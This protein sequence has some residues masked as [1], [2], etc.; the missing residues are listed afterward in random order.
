MNHYATTI[1]SVGVAAAVALSALP[2]R[3]EERPTDKAITHWVSEALQDDP[4]IVASGVAV[5]TNDGIVELSG[6]CRSLTG[7]KFAD[8]EAKKIKGVLGVIDKLKVEP[9]FR[10]DWDIAQDIRHRLL[11]SAFIRSHAL[12]VTVKDGYATLTGEVD[13]W[14]QKQWA[15]LLAGEVRG[16]KDIK[17][18]LKVDYS[19]E[20]PDKE[21]AQDVV[22]SIARDAYLTDLPITATVKDGTVTLTGSVGNWFQKDRAADQA[23]YVNGMRHVR[24]IWRSNGGKN[25]ACDITCPPTQTVKSSPTSS[26][27]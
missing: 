14:A 9:E 19:S 2:V 5:K 21:I 24:T 22:A 25:M 13:S 26:T 8:T 16:V 11:D 4:R 20:R 3:A 15:D 17:N 1:A 10:Y 18:N 7:K 12:D 6:S 23:Y 27:S